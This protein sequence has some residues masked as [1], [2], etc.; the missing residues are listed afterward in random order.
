[1]KRFPVRG[2]VRRLSI[3]CIRTI[4]RATCGQIRS[5]SD[6]SGHNFCHLA[7]RSL[8]SSPDALPTV[9]RTFNRMVLRW[10]G[11]SAMSRRYML[12]VRVACHRNR[13]PS[14]F[15]WRGQRYRIVEVYS[16]WHLRDRWW[17][18]ANP[19]G[20]KGAADRWYWR[21]ECMPWL[22]ADIYHDTAQNVWV[23]DRILD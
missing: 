9:E 10:R 8:T 6:N 21:V 22:Q 2:S 7:A 23:L 4:S 16:R 13:S 19:Y 1:M 18:T 12:P 20:G 3:Q 5:T 15:L 11:G 14:S 17:E